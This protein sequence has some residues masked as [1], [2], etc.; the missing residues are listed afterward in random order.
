MVD[1]RTRLLPTRVVVPADA[2]RSSLVLLAV[3]LDR[4]RATLVRARRRLVPCGSVFWVLWFIHSPGMGFGDVRL[5]ALLGLAL[6]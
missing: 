1:W 3:A 4:D 2:P 6:G 5:S